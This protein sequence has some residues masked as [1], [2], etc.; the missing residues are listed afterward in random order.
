MKVKKAKPGTSQARNAQTCSMASPGAM[1]PP[2]ITLAKIPS[3]GI[4]QSPA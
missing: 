3:L 1:V 4:T 2:L